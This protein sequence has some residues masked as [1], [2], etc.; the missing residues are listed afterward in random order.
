MMVERH[1]RGA[2]Q[3]DPRRDWRSYRYYNAEYHYLA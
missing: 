1:G 2:D 3:H